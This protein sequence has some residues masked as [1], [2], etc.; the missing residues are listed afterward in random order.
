MKIEKVRLRHVF[1]TIETDGLFWEERLVQ[2]LDVYEQFRDIGGQHR[3]GGSANSK[4]ELAH[5]A[6]FVQVETD[7]GVIGIGGPIDKAVAFIV[8]NEL[9]RYLIGRNP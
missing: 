6:Y 8:E 5:D 4:N 9:T 3:F 1:G 7:E 2:P